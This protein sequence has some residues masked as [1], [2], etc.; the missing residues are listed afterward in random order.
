MEG[1]GAECSPHRRPPSGA[2]ADEMPGPLDRRRPRGRHVPRAIRSA[3]PW[4][5]TGSE[6]YL[7]GRGTRAEKGN[8]NGNGSYL[9]E[10]APAGRRIWRRRWQPR[11]KGTGDG[12]GGDASTPPPASLLPLSP[13][14]GG[15]RRRRGGDEAGQVVVAMTTTTARE[16]GMVGLGACLGGIRICRSV[17]RGPTHSHALLGLGPLAA[18]TAQP[19]RTVGW[20]CGRPRWRALGCCFG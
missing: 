2:L 1:N 13:V 20:A 16:R 19:R 6:I 17:G 12:R 18:V 5:A 9:G 15:G 11:W 7:S 4:K 10:R 3:Q 14:D 8:G